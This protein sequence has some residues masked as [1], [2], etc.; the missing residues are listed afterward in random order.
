M[1]LAV[2]NKAENS[3]KRNV[4]V[5]VLLLMMVMTMWFVV[6]KHGSKRITNEPNCMFATHEVIQL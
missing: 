1:M 6:L 2:L 3:A 4:I 5:F